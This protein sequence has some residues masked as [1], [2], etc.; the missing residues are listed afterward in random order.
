MYY[1]RDIIGKM[2]QV[3]GLKTGK[4]ENFVLKFLNIKFV[5]SYAR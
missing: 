3:T 5:N 1:K 2:S 4:Q